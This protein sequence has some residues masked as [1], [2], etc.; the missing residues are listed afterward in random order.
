M[1]DGNLVVPRTRQKHIIPICPLCDTISVD[2]VIHSDTFKYGV[3]RSTVELSVELPVRS[4]QS[5]DITFLDQVGERLRHNAVCRHLGVLTPEEIK[6]IR[7]CHQMTKARFSEVTG[8]GE[9]T[10][11]RWEAGAVIQNRANDRYLRLL[12]TGS[13]MERLIDLVG[14]SSNDPDGSPDD[15]LRRSGREATVGK[16]LPTTY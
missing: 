13:T 4:C 16:N 11:A 14:D 12:G 2:T 9:A 1:K 5:C 7:E 3:G 10:L 8:L 6:S 15:E